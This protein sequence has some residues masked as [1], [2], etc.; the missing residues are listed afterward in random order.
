MADEKETIEDTIKVWTTLGEKL[1]NQEKRYR[2]E[3]NKVISVVNAWKDTIDSENMTETEKTRLRKKAHMAIMNA[4]QNDIL[5]MKESK[6]IFALYQKALMVSCRIPLDVEAFSR[7]L[8][9][10]KKNE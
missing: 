4:M 10:F 7:I 5:L 8:A 9:E 6:K 2:R 3:Y 1:L